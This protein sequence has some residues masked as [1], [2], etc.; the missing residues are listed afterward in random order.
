MYTHQSLGIC[1]NN[2]HTLLRRAPGLIQPRGSRALHLIHSLFKLEDMCMLFQ[3][4]KKYYPKAEDL[5]LRLLERNSTPKE[6]K[7]SE[8]VALLQ[9]CSYLTEHAAGTAENPGTYRILK[10]NDPE[11]GRDSVKKF[12][13]PKG[14]YKRSGRSKEFHFFTDCA[15]ALLR[16]RLKAA[17]NFLLEGSRVEIHLRPRTTNDVAAVDWALAHHLHLRPESI[18]A[19]MPAGTTMLTELGTREL[20]AK[21]RKDRRRQILRISEVFWA[22][23]NTAALTRTKGS[24]PQRIKNIATWNNH[25][26]L[27]LK[28]DPKAMTRAVKL[29]RTDLGV[30]ASN[31]PDP[32]AEDQARES[33]ELPKLDDLLPD[34]SPPAMQPRPSSMERTPIDHSKKTPE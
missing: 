18:L 25:R 6:M 24:T 23:E 28:Y 33:D 21:S 14:Y 31:L 17:Y 7:L 32:V 19:A 16:H 22:M 2:V 11:A 4:K 3:V 10:F 8:A 13:P 1:S 12:D 5:S 15:A 9:P 29:N 27:I 20:D 34:A 30:D 26:N